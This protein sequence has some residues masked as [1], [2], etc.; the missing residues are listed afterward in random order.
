MGYY[1][2]KPIVIQAVQFGDTDF[3]QMPNWLINEYNKKTWSY[4]WSYSYDL[5]WIRN[6]FVV[7][8]LEGSMTGGRGDYI[9]QG[10]EGELYPCRG[11]IFEKTYEKAKEVKD[12]G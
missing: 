6:G 4:T 10:V 9:V 12:N 7:E 1:V 11:D 8:T 2:K 5:D 3:K